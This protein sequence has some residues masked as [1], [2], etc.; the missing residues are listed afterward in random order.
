M[1]LNPFKFLF[2]TK[3]RA[4]RNLA[5][6]GYFLLIW[7]FVGFAFLIL[8]AV[9]VGHQNPNSGWKKASELFC[10]EALLSLGFGAVGGL[11]GFLFGIPRP[12]QQS[13]EQLEHE[14]TDINRV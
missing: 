11:I 7:Q 10:H 8:C 6:A 9:A 2:D 14:G 5:M 13:A 12:V 4:D 3:I 1:S